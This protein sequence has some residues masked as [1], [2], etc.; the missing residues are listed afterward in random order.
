MSVHNPI[1][2]GSLRGVPVVKREGERESRTQRGRWTERYKR[3][4]GMDRE[5]EAQRDKWTEGERRD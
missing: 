5:T 2:W 4:R 1:H 3:Y